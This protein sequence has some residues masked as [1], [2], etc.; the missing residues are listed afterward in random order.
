MFQ[1]Y[2]GF[3]VLVACY[4]GAVVVGYCVWSKDL[5][6]VSAWVVALTGLVILWYTWETMQLRRAAFLQREVQLRPFLVFRRDDKRYVVENIGI[7]AALDIRLDIVL[8]SDELQMEIRFPEPIPLLK[9]ASI[10]EIKTESYVKGKLSDDAFTAHL[11]P[12]YAALTLDVTLRFSNVEGKRYKL[13]ET[14]AP[15]TLS[16]QGFRNAPL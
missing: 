10:A 13:I 8:V 14:V 5:T 1:R 6:A 4:V 2:I 9:P 12:K 16:I 7:G 15:Q 3:A 11:D